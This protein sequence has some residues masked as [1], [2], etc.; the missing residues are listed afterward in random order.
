MF[1]CTR[2]DSTAT[3]AQIVEKVALFTEILTYAKDPNSFRPPVNAQGDVR[4]PNDETG[5]EAITAQ[6]RNAS[7]LKQLG[8]ERK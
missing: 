2:E 4:R 3:T 6:F 1:A 8:E 7:P 5:K